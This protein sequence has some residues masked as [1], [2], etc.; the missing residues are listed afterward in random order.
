LIFVIASR[1]KMLSF[2]AGTTPFF[3]KIKSVQGSSVQEI[4]RA[5]DDAAHQQA[6][7]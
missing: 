1:G 2:P 6:M 3:P 5:P 4:P 7:E